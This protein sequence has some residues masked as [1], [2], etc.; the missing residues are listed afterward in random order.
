[1]HRLDIR[2]LVFNPMVKAINPTEELQQQINTHLQ[3]LGAFFSVCFLK[4]VMI[5]Y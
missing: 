3:Q 4:N 5:S 2:K 1:M